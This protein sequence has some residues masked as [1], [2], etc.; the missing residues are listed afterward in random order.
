MMYSKRSN[1]PWIRGHEGGK[2]GLRSVGVI[3][4][5]IVFLVNPLLPLV[6]EDGEGGLDVEKCCC[7]VHPERQHREIRE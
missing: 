3:R 1:S 7:G 5:P 2:E 6:I 4:L